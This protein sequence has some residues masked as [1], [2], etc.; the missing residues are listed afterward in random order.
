MS[1]RFDPSNR[2]EP[3]AALSLRVAQEPHQYPTLRDDFERLTLEVLLTDVDLA[4]TFTDVAHNLSGQ[5][6]IEQTVRNARRAYNVISGKRSNLAISEDDSRQ[7]DSK[8]N[9]LRRRLE[10]LGEKFDGM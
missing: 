5:G 1:F 4:L 7:L 2:A 9:L 3:A 8:L 10:E 6:A